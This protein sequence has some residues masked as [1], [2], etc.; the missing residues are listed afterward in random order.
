MYKAMYENTESALKQ[1]TAKIKQL[2]LKC[3]KQQAEATEVPALRQK[4][5]AARESAELLAREHEATCSVLD[6]HD[7]LLEAVEKELGHLSGAFR[8]L[9][10]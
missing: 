10:L 3:Q 6:K 5:Q 8:D 4:L 7:W 9:G 1:Q 2:E